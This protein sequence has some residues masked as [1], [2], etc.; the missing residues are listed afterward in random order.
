MVNGGGTKTEREKERNGEGTEG[1]K[2][3][4]RKG[5]RKRGTLPC[6]RSG[7]LGVG[8]GGTVERRDDRETF[9][10]FLP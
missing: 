8:R 2:Q 5:R 6:A 4:R 9:L 1:R 10:F 7:P 3:T